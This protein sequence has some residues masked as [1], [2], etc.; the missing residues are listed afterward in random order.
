[1]ANMIRQKT[2]PS[3]SGLLGLMKASPLKPLRTET[4]YE[5]ASRTL[6]QIVGT[7]SEAE[8][9]PAERDYLEVLTILVRDY[10]QK[11]RRQELVGMGPADIVRHLM[12]ENGMTVTELGNVIGSRTAA[13][14]IV[15]GRRSPS[16][17]YILRLADRFAVDPSLFLEDTSGPVENKK[18][19]QKRTNRTRR[20][21]GP[22]TRRSA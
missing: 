11:R 21:L 17:A 7:K 19:L 14:M 4:D 10:Q 3:A 12:E 8:F 13:S 22:V 9:T 5:A 1:M 15:N 18:N 2:K 6:R 16:K 20:Q